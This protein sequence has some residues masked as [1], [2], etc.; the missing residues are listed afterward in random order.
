MGNLKSNL[1]AL[2]ICYR[3]VGGF[4]ALIVSVF[5]VLELYR[6][7]SGAAVAGLV[8]GWKMWILPLL[9][10]VVI[11]AIVTVVLLE[12]ASSLENRERRVFCLVV[13][14]LICAFFPLGTVLGV[15]TILLLS[16]AEAERA[17]SES[18]VTE[19]NMEDLPETRSTR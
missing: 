9:V 1:R 2:A 16:R 5:A 18:S 17:F 11:G 6:P 4:M 7:G 19:V 15:F 10:P 8:T 14:W 12:V 13:A 3:I